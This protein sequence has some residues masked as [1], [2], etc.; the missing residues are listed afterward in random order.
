MIF[1]DTD[2]FLA[3]LK[4]TDWLKKTAQGILAKHHGDIWTSGPV[5]VELLLLAKRLEL[6]PESLLINVLKVATLHHGNDSLFLQAA[7][8]IRDDHIG[9][10]DAVHATHCGT[11]GTII[12]SDRVFDRLGLNRI[13]LEEGA[14]KAA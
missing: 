2:F 4:P 9:V 7:R 12:S 14:R 11:D 10:F 13:P 3:L 6:D 1:A 8:H 5:L